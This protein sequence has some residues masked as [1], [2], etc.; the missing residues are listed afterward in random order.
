MDD[1]VAFLRA[2]LDEDEQ[3]ARAA[4]PGPWSETGRDSVGEGM[5]HSDTTGWSVVGSVKTGY[6]PNAPYANVSLNAAHIARHD[7]A[8][9]LR[10]V[11]ARR[12]IVNQY[13][14]VEAND[15]DDAYEYAD[16]WANALGLA[17]RQLAAVYADHPSYREE[18][19]P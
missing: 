13:A 11:E 15:T 1:L 3:T 10:D 12:V 14:E 6:G 2:R 16:G 18:W 17:V 5:V 19:R 4:V 7:P 8:R 9:V